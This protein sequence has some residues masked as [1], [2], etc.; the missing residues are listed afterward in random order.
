MSSWSMFLGRGTI[1]W[2]LQFIHCFE[3]Q[4]L[5]NSAQTLRVALYQRYSHASTLI[6][7]LE[8][9]LFL[10]FTFWFF[11]DCGLISEMGFG[12]SFI[13]FWIGLD[14]FM[15]LIGTCILDMSCVYLFILSLIFE[16]I[17]YFFFWIV[18]YSDEFSWIV[19]VQYLIL[20]A[21]MVQCV[22]WLFFMY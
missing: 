15:W 4:L 20:Y 7:Q 5:K 17:N 3:L 8:F 11:M 10:L 12:Q 6:N 1:Q 2:S 16:L 9:C 22:L 19:H 21:F 14:L 18:G 13:L